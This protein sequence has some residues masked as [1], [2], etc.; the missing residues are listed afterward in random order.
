M[1]HRES[2]KI[3][4][5]ANANVHGRTKE[6]RTALHHAAYNGHLETVKILIAAGSSPVLKDTLNPR[7]TPLEV[8]KQEGHGVVAAV[9]DAVAKGLEGVYRELEQSYMVPLDRNKV[10]VAGEG[11]MGKTSTRKALT[12]AAFDPDEP[13]TCG[14]EADD[15]AIVQQDVC[16]WEVTVEPTAEQKSRM[17]ET[18]QEVLAGNVVVTDLKKEPRK[19]SCLRTAFVPNTSSSWLWSIFTSITQW[20]S[21]ALRPAPSPLFPPTD[22]AKADTAHE[23]QV[24]VQQNTATQD[25]GGSKAETPAPPVEPRVVLSLWDLAGQEV[26]MELHR[27]FLTPHGV[28]VVVFN[29]QELLLR[30]GDCLPGRPR[31]IVDECTSATCLSQL[32]AWLNSIHIFAPHAPIV[33][34][35]TCLDLIP[36][37]A[38]A[39]ALPR[40]SAIIQ[41]EVLA[42]SPAFPS[43]VPPNDDNVC[44]FFVDNQTRDPET[45]APDSSVLRLREAIM[46]LATSTKLQPHIHETAPWT[47][48]TL[49]DTLRASQR[50]HVSR[51]HLEA[52]AAGCGLGKHPGLPLDVEVIEMLTRFNDLGLLLWHYRHPKVVVLD[53]QWLIDAACT[54]IRDPVLH[55]ETLRLTVLAAHAAAVEELFYSGVLRASL[56]P[57]LLPEHIEPERMYILDVMEEF[58]LAVELPSDSADDSAWLIPALLVRRA[59][60]AEP[61]ELDPPTVPA[62][63]PRC[64]V[65]FATRFK[66]CQAQYSVPG[67]HDDL[68]LDF[69]THKNGGAVS[70]GISTLSNRNG[71]ETLVVDAAGLNQGFLPPGL[72]HRLI[73]TIVRQQCHRDGFQLPEIARDWAQIHATPAQFPTTLYSPARYTLLLRESLNSIEL[74]VHSGVPSDV[75]AHLRAVIDDAM[76]ARGADLADRVCCRVLVPVANGSHADVDVVASAA[77]PDEIFTFGGVPLSV[78]Q[79]NTLPTLCPWRAGGSRDIESLQSGPTIYRRMT[80]TPSP[81]T[82]P[83]PEVLI[84][85]VLISYATGHTADPAGPDDAGARLLRQVSATLTAAGISHYHG[86]MCPASRSWQVEWFGRVER[87]S[88]AVVLLSPGYLQSRACLKELLALLQCSRLTDADRIIPVVVAPGVREALHGN[89]AGDTYQGQLQASAVR[90]LCNRNWLPPPDRGT[91]SNDFNG[92]ATTLVELIHELHGE[93]P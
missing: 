80:L 61:G 70:A 92:N 28:Y 85:D 7:S 1:G 64:L 49:L 83:G 54:I 82:V 19:F 86:E 25:G 5:N 78:S 43:V 29:T 2:V 31:M 33:V 73:G 45:G 13:S 69:T 41:S 58:G 22:L 4:V 36:P 24:L 51:A 62:H 53:P 59:N 38:R 17:A 48:V 10:I 66:P 39:T 77:D 81:E 89:F 32:R 63:H 8:A 56:L 67:T 57:E 26:F 16:R 75:L 23:I 52:A 14:I 76:S 3:L 42:G 27:L 35:G 21:A 60:L 74:I 90:T 88:V 55:A 44:C 68:A 20:Y 93:S 65:A 84:E 9:L 18:I 71:A 34:V 47:W 46:R 30:P 91:F 12:G 37:V 40:L 50:K 15:F 87:C 72:F 6:G 79:L 11:R